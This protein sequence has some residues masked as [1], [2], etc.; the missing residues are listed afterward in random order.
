[1][2]PLFCAVQINTRKVP[3]MSGKLITVF[4]GSGF[5]GRHVV[6]ALAREGHK[7]RVAVRRPNLAYFLQPAGDVGQ[8]QFVQA[9]VKFPQSVKDAVEGAEVVINLVG[10][11][12]QT[13]KQKFEKIHKDGAKVIAEAAR[14]AGVESL[15][16][17]SALGAHVHSK[18][19]YARSKAEG[20]LAVRESFPSAVILRPS[21]VFGPEDDFFNRF[22]GLARVSPVLPLIGGGHT[23]FQPVYVGDVARAV[24]SSLQDDAAGRTYELGGPKVYTLREIF[25]F[26]LEE[27]GRSRTL[28]PL[29]FRLAKIQTFFMGVVPGWLLPLFKVTMDQVNLLKTDNVVGLSDEPVLGTL[30]DLGVDTLTSVEANVPTYLFRFKKHGQFD[31]AAV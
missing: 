18:S 5:I 19:A 4:G 2:S 23:K 14:E 13:G 9:N 11:L 28:V 25:E 15:I 3:G 16:H 31:T 17:L 21:V 6:R 29:S 22:A 20:E 24:L 26:T 1:M 27:T 30:A 12:T 8:I 10:I 7:I